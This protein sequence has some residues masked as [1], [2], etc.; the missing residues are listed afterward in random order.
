MHNRMLAILNYWFLNYFPFK[1]YLLLKSNNWQLM[2][3]QRT[4]FNDIFLNKTNPK[5]KHTGLITWLCNRLEPEGKVSFS[6][7]REVLP[8]VGGFSVL[9]GMVQHYL[10]QRSKEHEESFTDE[11]FTAETRLLTRSTKGMTTKSTPIHR[12]SPT[13]VFSLKSAEMK[14][15]KCRLAGTTQYIF[16]IGFLL[17]SQ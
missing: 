6:A 7:A 13:E 4:E 17:P 16:Q 12:G 8:V 3:F 10:L 2:A 14:L 15:H 9:D 1:D 5:T 11:A